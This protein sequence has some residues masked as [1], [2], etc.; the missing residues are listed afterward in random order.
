MRHDTVEAEVLRRIV[1]HAGDNVPPYPSAAEMIEGRHTASETEG[2]VLQDGAGEGEA[3]IARS[4]SAAIP[5]S[6][7]PL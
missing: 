4:S 1:T 3:D 5:S 2:M 6:V 7:I